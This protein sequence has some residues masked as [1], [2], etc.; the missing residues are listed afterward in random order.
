MSIR[1]NTPPALADPLMGAPLTGC[2]TIDATT[3]DGYLDNARAGN[4]DAGANQNTLQVLENL[5]ALENLSPGN[6][7]N[8]VGHGCEGDIDTGQAWGQSITLGNIDEW[9]PILTNL[10]GHI[11]ELFLFGCTV[12]A[13]QDGANLLFE[14]AKAVDAPVSAPTGLIYCDEVGA[15]TLEAGAVWQ[16]ATPTYT[17]PPI[18]PPAHLSGHLAMSANEP[19][20]VASATYTPVG[21]PVPV[22]D[23]MALNLANQVLWTPVS[24]PGEPGGKNTGMLT[25]EGSTNGQTWTRTFQVFNHALLQDVDSL[26]YYYAKPTFRTLALKID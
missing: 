26:A 9:T 11:T 5:L 24:L 10:A 4:P 22:S 18:D 7:A 15:F 14:I 8:I 25:V 21:Q 16:T 19:V 20:L 23:V 12:G 17:P 6:P 13:G 1:D 2:T 3:P